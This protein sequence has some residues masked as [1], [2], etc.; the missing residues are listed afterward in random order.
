MNMVYYPTLNSENQTNLSVAIALKDNLGESVE[1]L[2]PNLIDMFEYPIKNELFSAE[3]N[4]D[5]R[6]A[7]WVAFTN[8]EDEPFIKEAFKITQ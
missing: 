6:S 8:D 1:I 3:P 7:N 2:I 4:V 5:K